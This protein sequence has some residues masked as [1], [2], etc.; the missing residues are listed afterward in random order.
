MKRISKRIKD[1]ADDFGMFV[2]TAAC[3]FLSSYLPAFRAGTEIKIDVSW[4]RIAIACV[5]AIL[6]TGVFEL[7]GIIRVVDPVQIAQVKASRRRNARL[8]LIVSIALG[9]A[10]STVLELMTK[11]LGLQA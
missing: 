10:S 8:R 9:F 3:A 4:G 11:F 5:L 6:V 1:V 7:R 2:L